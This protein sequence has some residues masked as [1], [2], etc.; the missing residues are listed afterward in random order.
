VVPRRRAATHP[1]TLAAFFKALEEGQRIADTDRAAA[2]QAMVDMQARSAYPRQPAA[3]MSLD[4]F[5]VSTG[6][7]GS[8]D[9]ARLQRVVDVMQQFLGFPAFNISSMLMNGG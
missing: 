5:P 1:R 6:P 3:V 4:S 7:V 9:K 8:V 2:E